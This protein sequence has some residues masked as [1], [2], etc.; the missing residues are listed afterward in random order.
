MGY[1]PWDCKESDRTEHVCGH[2]RMH[3]HTHTHTHTH[4]EMW[5]ACLLVS[6]PVCEH[7]EGRNGAGFTLII[8]HL[9][10]HRVGS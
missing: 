8:W 2:A 6:L 5:D 4:C 3:T 9:V 7:F 1:S 10:G